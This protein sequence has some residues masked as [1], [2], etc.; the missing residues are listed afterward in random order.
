MLVGDNFELKSEHGDWKRIQ[1]HQACIY[2]YVEKFS[3][4]T[5]QLN[6]CNYVNN[7]QM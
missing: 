4:L 1:C 3:C 6:S 2:L 5:I 7:L